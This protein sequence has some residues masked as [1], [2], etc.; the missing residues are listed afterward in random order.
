[1]SD[2]YKV[3]GVSPDATDE[4]VKAAYRRLA[5]KYHPDNY[6]DSPLADLAGEKMKEI[7]EA[8][9]EV[10]KQ[11]KRGGSAA[12]GRAYGT[13]GSAYGSSGSSEY[14][15]VREMIMQ[16]R[17]ADAEQILDGVPTESRNAE[18]F[19]LK[20]NILY[21]RGWLEEAYGDFAQACRMD[22]SNAEYRAAFAQATNQR[23]GMYGGYNTVPGQFA[24][25]DGCDI[26]T[27]LCAANLCCDCFSGISP[28]C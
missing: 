12:S 11:R 13:D 17:L 2:P 6:A 3:L 18:W 21:R 15:D 16:G 24:N 8:Y 23:R 27:T 14:L 26:C 9:D 1:M 28:C 10:V 4:E 20:G 25:C 7:N 22:P 19:Y 5:K